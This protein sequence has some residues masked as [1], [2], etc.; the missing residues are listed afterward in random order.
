MSKYD[1]SRLGARLTE[2]LLDAC[3]GLCLA[4]TALYCA[5]WLI[6]QIWLWLVGTLVVV[7][8]GWA[9]LWWHRRW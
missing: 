5:V 1:P 2:R 6:A 8:I 3:I 9:W 7:G 4:A